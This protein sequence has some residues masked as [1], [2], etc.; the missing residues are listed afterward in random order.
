MRKRY[1]ISVLAAEPAAERLD[2]PHGSR[3]TSAVESAEA[4]R[5]RLKHGSGGALTSDRGCT[6]PRRAPAAPIIENRE[7]RA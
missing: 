1:T 3:G 4:A 7:R 6:R 2:R 5:E